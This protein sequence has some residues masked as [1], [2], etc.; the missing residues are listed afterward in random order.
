MPIAADLHYHFFNGNKNSLKP[1]LIL[2]HG[3]G[4]NLLYWPPALRRL[5]GYRVYAL[6][7]PGH[8]GS[9]GS[10]KQSI[11]AYAEAIIAWMEAL[12]LYR[13]V[14]AGHSM[15]SA[16]AL[17]LALEYSNNT[18]GLI[19]IG[20]GSRLP[21]NKQLLEATANETTFHKAVDSIVQWSFSPEAPASLTKLAYKQMKKT[22]PSVLYGDLI[23]CNSFDVTWEI[24][25]I[26]KPT[27]IICGKDDKMTPL[28][29]SQFLADNISGARLITI[30]HAGHM[31][32]L[33]QPEQVANALDSFLSPL[34]F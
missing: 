15:G 19:L 26:Q 18:S 3:A 2:I 17:T 22:R 21:V 10:G 30:P 9:S 23:A 33:E 5:A 7:L 32:M 14:F 13:A 27:L 28:R 25:N 1:P 34:M 20:G 8:G 11:H 12:N 4:G 6:D 24:P 31:V 29:Y 16:I